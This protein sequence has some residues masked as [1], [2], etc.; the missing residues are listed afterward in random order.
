MTSPGVA[1][2]RTTAPTTPSTTSA[3]QGDAK[4]WH[5]RVA[6][7]LAALAAA[8]VLAGVVAGGAGLIGL[9]SVDNES[10]ALAHVATTMKD[11]A[12]LRDGEGDMRVAVLEVAQARKAEDL[13]AAVSDVQDSDGRM[14]TLATALRQ[15][16]AGDPAALGD[17]DGFAQG[18]AAWRHVRDTRIV[19]AARAGDTAKAQ[20][21]V[22]GPLADADDAFA[23]PLDHLVDHIGGGVQPA[24][25]STDAAISRSTLMVYAALTL[26]LVVSVVLALAVSRSLLRPLRRVNDV[27]AALADGDLT[28]VTEVRSK[29]EMGVMAAA[30]DRAM[31]NL[32]DTVQALS[33]S[34]Q[35]LAGAS[36]ELSANSTQIAAAASETAAE[37]DIASGAVAQINDNVRSVA[38]GAEQMTASIS[39]ISTNAAEAARVAA[40]AVEAA[41]AANAQIAKL[42]TS[43]AEIGDVIKVITSI[44][45][46]TNLLALN[47]TIEAAR[48]GEAGKGFAVVADEVKQLAQQTARATGEIGQRIEAIQGDAGGAVAAIGE[49]AAVIQR[50]N[51]FQTTIA[52]AVE[53]QTATTNEM[54]QNVS[55]AA[56]SS[57]KVSTNIT[58]VARAA[59]TT[60]TGVQ[61][62][63]RAATELAT[64][65]AQLQN[66][67]D[68]F[69]L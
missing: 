12:D 24:S 19:P 35:G 21:A 45:E 58:G 6:T 31:E 64:M 48:A 60:T 39:E 37:V 43:S 10:R 41:D 63:E 18:L 57:E 66:I 69:R 1:V 38:A 44:A 51:D 68:R 62:A 33:A 14:D 67:V 30:L 46:Q 49:I 13:R 40:H 11:V 47:A 2:H 23:G 15:D 17:F 26:G 9:S 7:K 54:S 16:V 36:E 53:E 4:G 55:V 32:R 27:L 65:S 20:A 3:P 34:A 29:D 22:T 8:G 42:G 59:A 25:A 61:D 56:Q 28:K 50:I 52:S 5:P